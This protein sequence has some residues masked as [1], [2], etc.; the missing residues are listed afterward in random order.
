MSTQ[1]TQN[2]QAM[3]TVWELPLFR[4][5]CK[6]S[7]CGWLLVLG[8]FGA[9]EKWHLGAKRNRQFGSPLSPPLC[10]LISA[11]VTSS[12]STPSFNW[13][14]TVGKPR[15]MCR[16]DET[17]SPNA[18]IVGFTLLAKLTFLSKERAHDRCQEMEIY[19]L[20]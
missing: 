9:R 8:S 2:W 15:G 16:L 1:H 18:F 17:H 10:V 6:N 12:L 13:I 20:L 14:F 7:N 5:L 11:P 4:A 3:P 19:I